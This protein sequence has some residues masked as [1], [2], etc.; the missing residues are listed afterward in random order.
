MKKITLKNIRQALENMRHEVTISP[1]V[2]D[3]ARLAV[4]RMI[5]VG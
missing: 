3:R 2:A 4:E 5:A 1:D